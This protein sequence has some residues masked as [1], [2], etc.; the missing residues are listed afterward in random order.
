[1]SSLSR[2]LPTLVQGQVVLHSGLELGGINGG[3]VV[4]IHD[5]AAMDHQVGQEVGEDVVGAAAADQEAVLARDQP[6]RVFWAM[7][8]GCPAKE[9]MSSGA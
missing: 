9:S 6:S 5:P 7:S 1:M 3:V 2:V 4:L 8:I